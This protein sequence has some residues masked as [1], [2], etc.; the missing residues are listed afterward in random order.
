VGISNVHNLTQAIP[1]Q[2]ANPYGV[3]VSLRRGDPFRNLL[4]EDW[5][6]THWYPTAAAR[7]VALEDMSRKHEYSRTGDA[8][9]LAFDKVENLALSRSL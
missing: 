9:A 8:P 7:D 3:R 6:R 1:V 2:V 5:S 4:G